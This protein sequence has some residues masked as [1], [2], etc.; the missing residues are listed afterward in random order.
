MTPD[1]VQRRAA[2]GD[3]PRLR[4]AEQLVAAEADDV[5]A[6]RDALRDDR[7]VAQRLRQR[8]SLGPSQPAASEILGD[9][10]VEPLP[11]RDQLVERRALG[12]ADDAEVR[13]MDAEDERGAIADRRRVVGR[14][15]AVGRPHLAQD[16][17]RL[18]HHVGDAEAA[19][20]LDQLAAR[21]DHL[22]SRRQRR[23]QQH[24]RGGVVVDDDGGLGAG[25]AGDERF[26]VDVTPSARAAAEVVL[27]VG[28]AAGDFVDARQRGV[29]QRR[30]PRLVWTITP[31]ALI[32]RTSDGR[33]AARSR[34]SA[35]RSIAS[36][37]SFSVTAPMCRRRA[38]RAALPSRRAAPRR[39]R[40]AAV[41][42]L[43]RAHRL[44][45]T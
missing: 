2:P 28:V 1:D 3:D 9:G 43:E 10:D 27:E 16:R 32:T 30:A 29:G 42:R 4:A 17:A 20:D 11:E 31:V 44:A 41:A 26:G 5:E 36:T 7:L 23:Q 45:L 15:G 24:R 35:P 34:A 13:G 33:I 6:R 21:D 18:R 8:A 19:A 14:A 22:A 38:A 12:E 39:A 25:E 37:A 40:R